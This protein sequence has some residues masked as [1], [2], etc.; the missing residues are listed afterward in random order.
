MVRVACV[1]ASLRHMPSVETVRERFA[2]IVA[3]AAVAAGYDLGARGG[4]AD[5]ARAIG[6]DAS[7][8]GRML[9]GESLPSPSYFEAIAR[10]VKIDVLELLV[11][12]EII[13]RESL[14]PLSETSPSQV[15]SDA[16]TP[17]RAA[18]QLGITDP[19]AREMFLGTVERLRRLQDSE[20]ATE[21]DANDQRGGTAQQM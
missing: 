5:L 16:I 6:M 7:G 4:K 13:S 21:P 15:V 3:T 2:R 17:T 18:D 19:I 12:A 9:S 1:R 11:A 14:Q 10:A 8:V 20:T